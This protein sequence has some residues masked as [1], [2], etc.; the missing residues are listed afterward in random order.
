M[1]ATPSPTPNL[2]YITHLGR[3]AVKYGFI[4]LVVIMVGRVSLNAFVEFWKAT[5]P[6]PPPPPTAGFGKLPKIDFPKQSEKDKPK[7]YSLETATGRTPNFGD[8]AKVFF[9]PQAKANLL[10]DNRA[11][12][13]AAS[14][15]FIF[16]PE[17]LDAQTY[18]WTKTQPLESTLQVDL[19][20]FH[21]S[22]RT[23]Y[24]SRPDLLLNN[25]LPDEYDAVELVKG[26]LKRSDSMPID[27]ASSA[28]DIT[29]LKALGGDLE[30]AA[31]L[32]D[33]DFIRVDLNRYPIDDQFRMYSPEGYKGSISAVLTGAF[34]SNQS[35]VE[36]DYQYFNIDYFQVETYPIKTSQVAW[37]ILQAGEGF[38]VNKGE[39]DE[40]V[41]RNVYLG[42]YDSWEEQKYLQPVFV[43]EGD[44]DFLGYVPAVDSAF[45]VNSEE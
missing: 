15:G 22:L 43:F 18:R 35:V 17:M 38:I 24:L 23:D 8:R 3:Q 27:V 14:Y 42:Y 25:S 4:V 10:A 19:Q 45:I 21:I 13:I 31:S 30:E 29:F 5:H 32:S 37:K 39:K 16:E 41:I 6:E 44:D 11:R 1:P 9:V 20:T 2:T 12:Q 26:F 36:I 40:A 28:G 34:K 7:Q 33:A